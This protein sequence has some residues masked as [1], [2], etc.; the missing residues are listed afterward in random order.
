MLLD[1]GLE[2]VRNPHGR[3]LDA[4]EIKTLIADVDGLLAGLEPLN[5]EV[6]SAARQLKAVARVGVG[7]D[8]VDLEVARA[9]GIRVSNTPD[10]PAAAVAE[11][12][13]AMTIALSRSLPRADAALHSGRWEKI[14]GKS[15]SESV[16]LIVGYGR[17]G[18]RV[19]EYL[20][21]FGPRLIVCDPCVDESDAAGLALSDLAD[22]LSQADIVTLHASGSE[23][24]L[25]ESAFRVMKPGAVLLSCG[26]GGQ[27]DEGA[28][29]RALDDGSVSGAWL[30]VFTS[31]PYSGPLTHYPQVI[32]T[33]HMATYTRQTRLAMELE[34][35]GNLLRDLDLV[36]PV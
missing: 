14:I 6:L 19:A 34:A 10:A 15:L 29:V 7:L 22:G 17:I 24:V 13:V 23:V 18:R 3:R 9:L 31:E 33:P 4:T 32:L 36:D 5:S 20:G 21:P 16:V 1:H 26:R 30:D 8:T 11:L 2:L 35:V 25:D 27:V 12:A 28:L